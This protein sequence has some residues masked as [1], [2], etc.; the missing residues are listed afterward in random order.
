MFRHR[1]LAQKIAG[2]T[3]D[4][5]ELKNEKALLLNQLDCADDHGIGEANN[6]LPSMESSLETL[7]QQEKKY[8]VE[9]DM[10]LAQY[11]ELQ[12][13]VA[14]MDT[15]ELDTTRHAIRPVKEYET[16][17]R[18]QTAYKKK[19]DYRMLAQN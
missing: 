9:L 15:T 12:Q 18:L 8:T 16:V 19:F 10:A 13:Q 2:L 3:E 5:E 11:A 1:E 14:D 17:Q 6:I 4:I 7:N